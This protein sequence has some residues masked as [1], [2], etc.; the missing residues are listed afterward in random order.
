MSEEFQK[1]VFDLFAQELD[2][3]SKGNQGTGLG[4]PISR[5]LARLMGGDITC[6][7]RKD[8]GSGAGRRKEKAGKAARERQKKGGKRVDAA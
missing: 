1:K 2:T 3:V 5:R 8:E 6:E 4:L 7:S